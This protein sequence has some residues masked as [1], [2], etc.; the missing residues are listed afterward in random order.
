VAFSMGTW[1]PRTWRGKFTTKLIE[2]SAVM[3]IATSPGGTLR[4][5]KSGSETT[6]I[7]AELHVAA[8]GKLESIALQSPAMAEFDL[9]ARKIEAM[10][11]IAEE[12]LVEGKAYDE[13][14]VRT[15]AESARRHTGVYYDNAA[16]ATVGAATA[17]ET[18][19]IRPYTS[20]YQALAASGSAATNMA[21]IE[22]DATVTAYRAAIKNAVEVAERSGWAT[23]LEIVMDRVFI[24]YFRDFPTDGSNGAAIWNQ[25]ERTILGHPYRLSDGAKKTTTAS[26]T[27]VGNELFIVGPRAHFVAGRAPF[28]TGNPAVP[29]AFL[30][31]PTT[32]IGMQNDSAYMKVRAR[33]AFTPGPVPEAFT[34]LERVP[35]VP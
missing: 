14:I 19:I 16:L 15:L 25:S 35:A 12:D 2:Q 17:G 22:A 20:V 10:A 24:S 7:G 30:S 21:T 26:D 9:R 27:P 11:Q 23:D 29:E 3:S 18:N 6:A 33:W 1:Q 31:D 32:G 8:Y 28:S 34:V 13:D 5:M 4:V